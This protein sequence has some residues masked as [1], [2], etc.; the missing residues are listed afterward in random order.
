M[1]NPG[2][3]S[4]LLLLSVSAAA[5]RNQRICW[6]FRFSRDSSQ[7]FVKAGKDARAKGAA[8]IL[9][10]ARELP[11][12]LIVVVTHVGKGLRRLARDSVAEAVV[13]AAPCTTRVV[14]LA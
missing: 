3:R 12:Q 1:E 5:S 13:R 11:A 9:Y 4:R 8:S 6:L 2:G 7:Y 14:R 10:A